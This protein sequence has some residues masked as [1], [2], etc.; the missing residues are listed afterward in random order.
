MS[1]GSAADIDAD[2]F[3]PGAMQAHG[4]ATSAAK[5]I[6]RAKRHIVPSEIAPCDACSGEETPA[7][8]GVSAAGLSGGG[9]DGD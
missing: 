6:E 3:E 8:Q 2:D 5:Q 4:C 9:S 1:D 7:S